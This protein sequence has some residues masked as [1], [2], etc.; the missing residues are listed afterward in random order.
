MT[1]AD[2][3][4][5][6]S[7]FRLRVELERHHYWHVHRKRVLFDAL[8]RACPDRSARL[9]ELGAGVGSVAT[10]FNA[11]GRHVDYSDV[12][13]EALELAEGA[14]RAEL[15]PGFTRHF[16]RLDVTRDE[17]PEGYLGYCMFDVLEHLTP[18][19]RVLTKLR[20]ALDARSKGFV[21]LSVPAF[22]LLW[23]PWDE[24]ERHKRRYTKAS[25]RRVA[26]AAGFRVEEQ[27]YFFLPLFFAA[28]G[29]KGVRLLRR[30]TVGPP[31]KSDIRGMLE[32]QSSPALDRAM[33]GL[34]AP[35]RRWL[36]RGDLMLGTSLLATLRPV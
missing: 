36:A 10:Y 15:G 28:L 33:L 22:S 14:A 7:E 25:L 6:P 35:E 30:A 2:A 4:F 31:P 1:D 32:T 9:L 23:S 24:L 17:I 5:D 12:H 34:L 26:E 13:G 16:L 19:E 29:V 3:D 21:L 20:S 11:R 8:E 18:H 27:R